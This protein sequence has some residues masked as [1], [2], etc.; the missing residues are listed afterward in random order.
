MQCEF[1]LLRTG[2]TQKVVQ[3]SPQSKDIRALIDGNTTQLLRCSV[4]GS[5]GREPL[6]GP[7]P[8]SNRPHEAKIDQDGQGGMFCISFLEHDVGRFHVAVHEILAVHERQGTGDLGRPTHGLT[9]Q[10]GT[11]ITQVSGQ[12]SPV[13]QPHRQ[14]REPILLPEAVDLRQV[15]VV[16][17]GENQR[18]AFEALSDPY[19]GGPTRNL[20]RNDASPQRTLSSAVDI[21]RRPRCVNVDDLEVAQDVARNEHGFLARR[22]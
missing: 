20:E 4:S 13:D 5:H 6:H 11:S 2:A 16:K 15:R 7:S 3:Q 1:P 14:V 18:L 19:L 9:R 10:N 17:L 12:I 8:A 21:A 22:A